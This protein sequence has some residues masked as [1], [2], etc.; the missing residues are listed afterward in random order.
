MQTTEK[1]KMNL[2]EA[3]DPVKAEYFNHNTQ[4]LEQ[5]VSGKVGYA[6]GSFP[7]FAKDEH[8]TLTF[9]RKP[10]MIFFLSAYGLGMCMRGSK[11]VSVSSHDSTGSKILCDWGEVSVTVSV[12]DPTAVLCGGSTVHYF[13]VLE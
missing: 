5:A 2:F 10:V 8:V 6:A 3:G 7:Y 9:D 11:G 1:L 13:A 4:V 12:S